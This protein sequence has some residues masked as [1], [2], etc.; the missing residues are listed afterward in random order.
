VQIREKPKQP[1]TNF[2]VTGVYFY[3][4]AVFEIVKTLRPSDRGEL[5]ITDVNNAYIQRRAMGF[6]VMDGWWTD[7]GTFESLHRANVLV[8][9]MRSRA[10]SGPGR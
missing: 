4:S 1:K 8:A 10:M 7:A 6:D 2:A 5:E 9:K 3:D